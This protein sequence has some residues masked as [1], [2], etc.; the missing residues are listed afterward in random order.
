M[1]KMVETV[2]RLAKARL[3]RIHSPQDLP[4]ASHAHIQ[5]AMELA[6]RVSINLEASTATHMSEMCATKTMRAIFCKGKIHP[7]TE[8][9]S[10]LCRPDD[11]TRSGRGGE[12]D[13]EIFKRII[14]EYK[15]IGLKSAMTALFAPRRARTSSAKRRSRSGRA[16]PLPNGLA[17]PG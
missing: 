12:S 5:E 3:Q 15:E 9:R 8:D 10:Q 17:L 14:Y 1:E 2:R 4:G 7:R 6:D 16:P 13:E 11:T